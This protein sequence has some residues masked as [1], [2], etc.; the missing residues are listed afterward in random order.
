VVTAALLRAVMPKLSIERANA[1][2]G[3]LNLYFKQ[4]Q[5]NNIRRISAF[6]GQVALE[7]SEFHQLEEN[8]NYTKPERLHAVFP[9]I[10]K[11]VDAA[12]EYTK[13]P[14][15]LANHIYANKI[16]NGDAASGDGWKYRGRGLI[17]LTGRENYSAFMKA[18]GVDVLNQPDLLMQPEYAVYS[19][20]W[21]W[22]LK[23]LNYRAD[24]ENYRELTRS[25]NS[26]GLHFHERETYRKRAAK[27][28]LRSHALCY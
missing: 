7:S 13:N 3:P 4:Y 27:V 2:T 6:L 5:I 16:G 8:L 15:K 12:K 9:K 20:A 24:T 25:V 26:A 11:T 17:Q 19:A 21:F 10:F 14:E 18:T 28:L 22:N 1:F 23:E